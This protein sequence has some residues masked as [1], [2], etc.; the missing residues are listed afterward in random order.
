[1]LS[2]GIFVGA[3]F[4]RRP[5]PAGSARFRR[6]PAGQF[7]HR[8]HDTPAARTRSGARGVV[9]GGG[10]FCSEGRADQERHPGMELHTLAVLFGRWMI[11]S[12]SKSST[13]SL[14]LISANRPHPP[15]DPA[16]PAILPK[17]PRASFVHRLSCGSRTP[18]A[19]P[20]KTHPQTSGSRERRHR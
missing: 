11:E 13:P 6:P 2:C 19:V 15:S 7:R 3:K 20:R 4:W 14:Y 8:F 1:M 12:V 18:P 5:Q 16:A 10:A 17:P 9:A